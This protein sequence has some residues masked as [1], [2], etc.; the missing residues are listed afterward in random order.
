MKSYTIYLLRHGLTKGNLNGQYIGHTDLPLASVG[1]EALRSYQKLAPYPKAQVYFS[2]PLKRCTE[3]LKILY[4][5]ETPILIPGLIEYNFGEFEGKTAAELK[6]S[7]AFAQWLGGDANAAPPFGESNYDFTV[8]ICDSF[9]KIVEGLMK[10]GTES[11]LI[12]T[13]GGVI[14]ALLAAFGLP[15]APM[16]QWAVDAGWGYVCRITPGIWMRSNKMEVINTL[17][18]TLEELQT[19]K[20]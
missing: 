13:H 5:K 18:Q 10:T 11:A 14:M 1:L 2:S 9:K 20:E 17:P 3:T 19:T 15:E 12:C 16:H 8:R 4:P 7:E 6:T